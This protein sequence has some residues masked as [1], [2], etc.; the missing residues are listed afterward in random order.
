MDKVT[1]LYK[2]KPTV[3]YIIGAG[4]PWYVADRMEDY[5]WYIINPDERKVKRIGLVKRNGPNMFE[6]AKA[7]AQKRNSEV[8]G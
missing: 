2:G 6:K 5:V 7:E 1:L 3:F 8:N 4:G